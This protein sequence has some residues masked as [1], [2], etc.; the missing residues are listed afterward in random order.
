MSGK[1]WHEHLAVGFTGERAVRFEISERQLEDDIECALLAYGPDACAGDEPGVAERV[2]GYG[3]ALPGGYHRRNSQTDYDRHRYLIP[4]DVIDFIYAT[5]PKEWERLK[6][7]HGAEV[8]EKFIARLSREI[9]RR[10]TLD[11]LRKGIKDSGCKFRLAYFRPVS[12]LNEELRRLYEANLFSVVR[13]LHYSEQ[14]DKSI[15]LAIFLNGIPL[16]TA[17]LKNPFNGQNVEDAIKQYRLD[18]DHREPLLKFRRCLAHFAVDPDLVYVT[19]E[20]AGPKTRFLPFNRG[21]HGGAGNPAVPPSEAMKHGGYA[22]AYLWNEVWGRDSVLNLIQHFIH[23][24]E[25]EDDKGKKTG[26]RRLIFPRYHQM[27][28]VRRLVADAK[29]RGSGKRYLIQHSAGSGKSNSIA[30]LAHQLSVLHDADDRSV[31][32]SVVVITDRRVLDRQLQRTIRQFEQTSGVVENIDQTSKQLKQA[33]EEGKKIIV[34]TLQKFPVISDQM[35]DLPGKRFAVI[36]DEAHSSQSGESTK[37]L[38]SVLSADG[39]DEAEREDEAEPDLEDKITEEV[40]TRG[41]LPNVSH[42]AFTA[43]PKPKT[44]ELFGTKG[45]DGKFHPF[46]LYSMR[47]AIEEGFILDVLDNYTTYETYW[48]LLK[49]IEDDPRFEKRKA[50]SLLKSYVDLHPHSI[51]KKIEIMV[52]HFHDQVAS[53]I[54]GKAKAMI[55]TRSRLHAVRYAI[56]LRKHLEAKGYP[57]KALVAFSGTVK[58]GGVDYTESALNQVSEKKTA[59]TFEGNE[60]RFLVVANKFQTGFDQPLLHTMYV[61]KK[62]SG[63]NAV[64][65]LSRLNRTHPGKEETSVLDFANS[66]D[67]IQESFQPYYERTILSKATDPNLLHDLER[68]LLEYD[69]Y[70]ESDVEKFAAT[71]FSKRGTQARLYGLLEPVV[72]RFEE[73]DADQKREFRHELVKYVRLYSFLSQIVA[74]TD[75]DL[76][77][78]YVFA[79]LLRKKLKVPREEL[80]KEIQDMI[81]LES[82]RVR[83]KGQ[84]KIELERGNGKLDP[85]SDKPPRGQSHSEAPLSDIIA[86]LNERFGANLS[87]EDRITINNVRTRLDDDPALNA[88]VR[89]N[90]RENARLTF[91]HKVGDLLQSIVDSNFNLYKRYADDK[92][93]GEMLVDH[94]F[95]EYI[96]RRRP[97]AELAKLPESSDLEFKSSLRWSLRE[98]KKDPAIVTHAVLKT[99]AAFLNTKGGDL[100]IGVADDGS[101]IGIEVDKFDNADKFLLHLSQQVENGLGPIAVSLIDP[102][103]ELV[104]GKQVCVVACDR[105]SAPILL[106]W[107]DTEKHADGDFFYRRGPGSAALKPEAANEFVAAR[108]PNAKPPYTAR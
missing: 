50:V 66:V 1:N 6:Q 37:H 24:F 70:S 61:D 29:S 54:N 96:R 41:P 45:T 65:T 26:K 92:S 82:L 27:D 108:F 2:V 71:Y 89:S 74:F 17:E 33:L 85:I 86:Q 99:I 97:A 39:L 14:N 60:Y 55:V 73:L 32:D 104:D 90:T 30:W 83:G 77:K 103:V 101:I 53:K 69:V 20:L 15:D 102:R 31:F 42:F 25:E 59:R 95:D 63:V 9:E 78:L 38:K 87:E 98:E 43:T 46:S 7:H 36:V 62:L 51:D 72:E 11:V 21:K 28:A 52:D 47:Q 64:Q 48:K 3:N 67:E 44:L 91:N 22:T 35:G 75:T 88:A 40:R 58:D 76:E 5:Q 84:G 13:Q 68:E 93:F 19:T 81:D 10:G 100:L 56:V 8:K 107:R 16:F 23:E 12:G 49:K 4:R 106:K 105:S 34:T 94:L 80:P 18:R 79:R 57:Y